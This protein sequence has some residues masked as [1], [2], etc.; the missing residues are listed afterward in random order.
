MEYEESVRVSPNVLTFCLHLPTEVRG[1]MKADPL[2]SPYLQP[3][4]FIRNERYLFQ[5]K[6]Q[7][8][9]TQILIADET[10]HSRV[11]LG[12][13]PVWQRGQGEGGGAE[14]VKNQIN[15]LVRRIRV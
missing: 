4:L 14:F 2:F 10:A 8:T 15:E 5:Y 7:L 13:R 6:I 11:H 3:G 9:A 1:P 12:R